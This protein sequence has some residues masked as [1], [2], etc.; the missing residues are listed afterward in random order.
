[1][2]RVWNQKIQKI[3]VILLTTVWIKGNMIV[4]GFMTYLWMRK[5]VTVDFYIWCNATVKDKYI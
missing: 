4:N 1:M 5:N 2:Y 3:I